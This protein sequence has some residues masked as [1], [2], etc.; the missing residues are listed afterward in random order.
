M[1]GIRASGMERNVERA[2]WERRSL[3]D[4]ALNIK[5][6]MAKLEKRCVVCWINNISAEHDLSDCEWM[7]GRC[8]V[9]L[10][11][12]HKIGQC[13]RARYGRGACCFKCGLPQRLGGV[14]IHGK[15]ATG[16]CEEGYR[17]KMGPLCWFMWR[18]NRWK[19]RLEACF[20][21]QWKE[22]EFREWMAGVEELEI[23]N[24]VRVMLRDWGEIE[25]GTR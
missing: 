3:V 6:M 11:P 13:F 1:L 4:T 7:Y 12:R 2:R 9:C 23:T 18:N 16:E 21:S 10:D 17:D 22:E 14:H 24:G 15:I 20:R 8:L 5:E 19:R 25:V